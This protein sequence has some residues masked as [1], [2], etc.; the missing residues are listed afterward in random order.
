MQKA[1]LVAVSDGFGGY[2]D[3]LFA[4]KLAQQLKTQYSKEAPTVY[5]VTQS[6]SQKQIRSLKGDVEFD[7]A[8]ITP[9]ELKEKISAQEIEVI[10]LIEG[11]IFQDE[12]VRDID[13]A[14]V[15]VRQLIPLTMIS[16]YGCDVL[17]SAINYRK[18]SLKNLA[19]ENVLY[20]G[21]REEESK[22][23]IL[24][25]EL[26]TN[27][28]L[29]SEFASQLDEKIRQYLFPNSSIDV[30]QEETEL[31]V[32]YSHDMGG[33]TLP[34]HRFFR[35]HC[36]LI[37]E[38]GKN[39]DVIVIGKFA[40]AK[41][42]ALKEIQEKLVADN[43]QRIVFYNTDTQ[44]EEILYDS[45]K[46]GKIYRT[47][48]K[49]HMSHPSMIAAIALS[50]PLMGATGDQSLGE[51]ISAGKW[52]IYE[53]LNHKKILIESYYRALV[54]ESDDDPLIKEALALLGRNGSNDD[55][56]RL[57]ELLQTLTPKIAGLNKAVREKYNLI[58][59]VKDNLE[60]L[61]LKIQVEGFLKNGQQQ[62]ALEMFTTQNAKM[63][64]WDQINRKSLFQHALEHDKNGV[65]VEYC[66]KA[67]IIARFL[68]S[69]ICEQDQ[70]QSFVKFLDTPSMHGKSEE[71]IIEDSLV[72]AA[73]QGNVEIVKYL[74][75]LDV[76]PSVNAIKKAINCC[77]KSTH[78]Q[79]I[80][81]LKCLCNHGSAEILNDAILFATNEARVAVVRFF[82]EE[83]S[84]SS[85]FDSSIISKLL[86]IV[87]KDIQDSKGLISKNIPR[88][89]FIKFLCDSQRKNRPNADS[90]A[91]T[92]ALAVSEENKEMVKFFC[93]MNSDNKPNNQAIA[94]ALLIAI[95]NDYKGIIDEFA[96]AD[97][98]N[99]E[100]MGRILIN[101]SST[102]KWLT[103]R[104]FCGIIGSREP[105][106]QLI[107]EALKIA[108]SA[109]NWSIVIDILKLYGN[110]LNNP[111][112]IDEILTAAC[113]DDQIAVMKQCISLDSNIPQKLYDNCKSSHIKLVQYLLSYE[114][115]EEVLI[116]ALKIALDNEQD[117][118][119][120]LL[121]NLPKY[122]NLMDQCLLQ[123]VKNKQWLAVQ[124]LCKLTDDILKTN[125]IGEALI[126][127][128][129]RSDIKTISILCSLII[130]NKINDSTLKAAHDVA[131]NLPVKQLLKAANNVYVLHRNIIDLQEYIDTILTEENEQKRNAKRL[132]N[133]LR[134]IS[135]QYTSAIF[136]NKT[137][138]ELQCLKEEFKTALKKTYKAMGGMSQHRE[139]WKVY[140]A[141][142]VIAATGIGLLVLA[143]KLLITG[144]GF[145]TE[146]RRQKKIGVIEH[147]LDDVE[148]RRLAAASA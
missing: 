94:D 27:P 116:N 56:Q 5:V 120:K 62:E 48:Y 23:G 138:V 24:I 43:F 18:E 30:Y 76:K 126:N 21:F 103:Y 86:M 111:L 140:F 127:A 72:Y 69:P 87:S 146:T 14:L 114:L 15:N 54:N 55:Y 4:L 124:E 110:N 96:S 74:C 70:N 80:E 89:E 131:G 6:T 130:K 51:A 22:Q 136:L 75:E 71:L 35:A 129:E 106:P 145:F 78:N 37:K 123:F 1:V 95:E 68:S 141:N 49:S 50:G 9:D 63:T 53:C 67:H 101:V 128:S 36:E 40:L 65:F 57:G 2:G 137:T 125:T 104:K 77:I 29:A 98:I 84:I 139:A 118:L 121:C 42:Q 97:K 45:G 82:L 11:P 119:A 64:I 142:I 117:K 143:A 25:S 61:F 33:T 81:I 26:L 85:G 83:A 147:A 133:D 107:V 31:S 109:K 122:K 102:N 28:G 19:Y 17:E 134:D 66:K 99:A 41:L 100:V 3:F 79:Q 52:V 32:Q 59:K 60:R 13:Q 148:T 10:H 73:S 88:W 144:T 108:S 44:E 112:V 20:S 58:T 113:G 12:L 7:V 115:E 135:N 39:Q 93:S 34:C 8:V 92:F 46:P 105:S 16:E 90:I 38:S 47:I 132:V 91:A